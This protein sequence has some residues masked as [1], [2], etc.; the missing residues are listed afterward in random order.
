M[1][2]AWFDAARR[3]DRERIELQLSSFAGSRDSQGRTALMHAAELGAVGIISLLVSEEKLMIDNT[4]N[5]ALS[6]AILAGNLEA[7]KALVYY[8]FTFRYKD[9]RDCLMLAAEVAGLDMVALLA[10]YVEK[11]LD[12]YGQTA[13]SFAVRRGDVEIMKYL[14]QRF[15]FT[16]QELLST[17]HNF[18]GPNF[19]EVSSLIYLQNHRLKSELCCNCQTL[20]TRML[21]L[22]QEIR[23]LQN[24]LQMEHVQNRTLHSKLQELADKLECPKDAVF[25]KLDQILCYLLTIPGN[26]F[27]VPVELLDHECFSTRS[28]KDLS[29]PSAQA[30][31]PLN[32]YILNT[33]EKYNHQIF[34]LRQQIETLTNEKDLLR[35][36]LNKSEHAQKKLTTLFEAK[37]QEIARAIDMHKE[38]SIQISLREDELKKNKDTITTLEAQN[39]ELVHQLEILT[40]EDATITKDGITPLMKSIMLGDFNTA[41]TFVKRYARKKSTDG[42]T[43][44]HLLLQAKRLCPAPVSIEGYSSLLSKQKEKQHAIGLI[45]M[46]IHT[47]LMDRDTVT[48]DQHQKVH[49]KVHTL[50][51]KELP[52][53]DGQTVILP[54]PP[55]TDV[56]N[57]D[58][59]SSS[60]TLDP[61]FNACVPVRFIDCQLQIEVLIP[62]FDVAITAELEPMLS[63]DDTTAVSLFRQLA[64]IEADLRN[65]NNETALELALNDK[66]LFAIDILAPYQARITTS[67]GNMPIFE[68]IKMA[69]SYPQEYQDTNREERAKITMACK[70]L[71]QY[72]VGLCSDEGT[73]SLM[74]AAQQNVQEISSLLMES[75]ARKQNLYG[76][77]ALMIAVACGHTQIVQDLA[78][79]EA[80]I[81]NND[82]VSALMLAIQLQRE[83]ELRI[84]L[85]YELTILDKQS[86]QPLLTVLHTHNARLS[87]LLIEE[88]MAKL[89]AV[90]GAGSSAEAS[91]DKVRENV[92]S[93]KFN[94]AIAKAISWNHHWQALHAAYRQPTTSE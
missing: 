29:L 19:V 31:E 81:L 58:M 51:F 60:N 36:K 21:S 34:I 70:I 7:A 39:A 49:Q 82:G 63:L 88:L 47:P 45:D 28:L 76:D 8:E 74:M 43:A 55:C 38:L 25:Q 69:T 52:K 85:P 20:T 26:L 94:S 89:R 86:E 16:E 11:N 22:E 2:D 46:Q 77:T 33:V 80:G 41:M 59:V 57:T 68:A 92:L 6:L 12:I 75:E 67:K 18:S 24:I 9:G 1:A 5:C 37:E 54:Q 71:L 90:F 4:D 30:L 78:P 17:L 62:Y 61:F 14:F 48:F 50:Q 93:F 42:M 79:L 64:K 32:R 23:R 65:K 53:R 27:K 15:N 66:N 91:L 56:S 40:Y 83:A 3:G 72:S 84:L 73:T 35:R 10:Q 44:L 13:L 87:Y